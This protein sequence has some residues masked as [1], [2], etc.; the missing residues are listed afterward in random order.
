MIHHIKSKIILKTFRYSFYEIWRR[1]G[2]SENATETKENSRS[3]DG[4]ENSR[5]T[6]FESRVRTR[7]RTA[8]NAIDVKLRDDL[9]RLRD[10]IIKW[11]E[12]ACSVPQAMNVSH[13]FALTLTFFST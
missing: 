5:G 2:A 12:L 13:C 6:R 11:G 3:S 7:S 9:S 8:S 10:D 4:I 1:P